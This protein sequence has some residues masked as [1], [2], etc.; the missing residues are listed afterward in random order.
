MTKKNATDLLQGKEIE[1]KGLK[2]KQGNEFDAK[3]KFSNGKVELIFNKDG[4]GTAKGEIIGKCACS[5]DISEL[6]KLY[7]CSNC[8]K[9]IWKNFLE[10]TITKNEAIDL[11]NEKTIFLKGLKSKAGNTFDARGTLIE[12]K[13]KL[14]FN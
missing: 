11:L 9:I 6:P 3:A 1:L 2:S 13:I 14:E 8:N 4:G 7:K 10:K 5:G 12:G